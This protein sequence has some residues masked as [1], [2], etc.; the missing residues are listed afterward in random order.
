MF[1]NPLR[2]IIGL[3]GLLLLSLA[4]WRTSL[5]AGLERVTGSVDGIPYEFIAQ[6]GHLDG[7]RPLVLIGHGY[8]GSAVIMRAFAY[9]LAQ[10]GYVAALW[11]FDGHGAN[12]N[13]LPSGLPRDRLLSNAEAVW[14]EAIRLGI[15]DYSRTAILGHSMG[16]GVA[17]EFGV[18]HPQTRAT[19]AVSPVLS[20]VT[21]DLPQ[22]LLLLAGQ[23]ESQFQRNA[24][25]LLK[26]AG[27]ESINLVTGNARRYIVI[28]WVEHV[29]IVF[30]PIAHHAARQWLD[31][32]IGRQPGALDYTDTRML[33]YAI[34]LLLAR[35]W[36]ACAWC[37]GLAL[38]SWHPI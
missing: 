13:P 27:G 10:A 19:I 25:I 30:S 16:S 18:Q 1:K 31:A 9:T 36:P 6:T 5:P 24:Q 21:L 38:R 14:G 15:G 35:C 26:Q 17:L 34:G 33:W 23:G 4:F 2:L 12:S 20:P 22:N 11:D 29:S 7:S 37:P 28:P 3:L 8:A 32:V